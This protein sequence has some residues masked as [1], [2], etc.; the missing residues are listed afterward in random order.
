MTTPNKPPA[1]TPWRGTM[2]PADQQAHE[3]SVDFIKKELLESMR[4]LEVSGG[5]PE[6]AAAP[7]ATA[8]R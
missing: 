8:D 2:T 6:P 3:D 1:E 7:H 4:T 5:R